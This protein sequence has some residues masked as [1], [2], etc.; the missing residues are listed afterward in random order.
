MASN[1]PPGCSSDDGG[2]DHEWE[3]AIEAISQLDITPQELVV[4]V[5]IGVMA[6]KAAQPLI[7][8]AV[9]IEKMEAS[10]RE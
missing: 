4:A 3:A 1:L 10:N 6:I 2:I 9:Q 5:K 8:L 7:D